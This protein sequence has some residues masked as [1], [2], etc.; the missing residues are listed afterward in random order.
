MES[1]TVTKL[2]AMTLV[3]LR[4]LAKSKQITLPSKLRKAEMVEYLIASL[5]SPETSVNKTSTE[6]ELTPMSRRDGIDEWEHLFKYGWTSIPIEG[7]DVN[8]YVDGFYTYLESCINP[9]TGELAGF[10]RNDPTTWKQVPLNLHGIFKHYMGHTKW[11]WDLREKCI[12]LFSEL[13]QTDDLLCSFDGANFMPPS[14]TKNQTK[15][16]FHLDQMRHFPNFI[17]AQGLVNLLPNGAEDGGLVV[18]EKSHDQFN[19]YI[20]SDIRPRDMDGTRWICQMK[21]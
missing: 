17:C 21:S 20:C 14:K 1:P 2:T 8:K 18:L 6:V 19:G 3:E 11:Q 4:A 13:W 12:P 7:L 9:N 16:W 15:Q 5:N 10:D